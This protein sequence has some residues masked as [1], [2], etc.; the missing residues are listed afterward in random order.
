MATEIER[1][2]LVRDESWRQ[3]VVSRARLTQAYL[4]EGPDRSLRVRIEQGSRATLCLK[5]GASALER[6]EFEYPVPLADA[7]AMVARAE[8]IVL[9]KTRHLVHFRGYLWEIDTYH[10]LYEGLTVAEVELESRDD[11]PP[12]PEW[13]GLEVTGD[14]RYS[15]ARLAASDLSGDLRHDPAP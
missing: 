13:I 4:M 3:A 5:I 8:G 9:D 2:F 6:Q 1:K 7:E 10:G 12:L 14:P 11:K 15:N